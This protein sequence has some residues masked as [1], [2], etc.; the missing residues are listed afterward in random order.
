VGCT[1]FAQAVI[2]R[3]QGL[4]PLPP[5]IQAICQEPVRNGS[6]KR[7][8]LRGLLTWENGAIGVR[9]AG[10]QLPTQFSTVA[11]STCLISAH[12]DRTLYEP[13]EAITVIPLSYDPQSFF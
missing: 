9:L 2:R 11:H 3:M 8:F 4:N 1:L 13:G 6:Q 12:E 5:T 10:G 7:H